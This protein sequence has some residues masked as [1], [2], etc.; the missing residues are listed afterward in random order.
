M[1]SYRL[2][3]GQI[4]TGIMQKVFK[5]KYTVKSKVVYVDGAGKKDMAIITN[6]VEAY[7]KDAAC[8]A[9]RESIFTHL[10]FEQEAMVAK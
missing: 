7:S 10:S 6:Y 8:K 3:P 1:T 5:K 9:A 2:K 4:V